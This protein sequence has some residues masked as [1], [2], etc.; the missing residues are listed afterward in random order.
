MLARSDLDCGLVLLDEE[1]LVD[2]GLLGDRLVLVQLR[3][4][5]EV[6]ARLGER[7]AVLGERRLG[8]LLVDLILAWIDLGE[9]LAFLHVLAFVITDSGQ[10]AAQLRQHGDGRDGCHRAEFAQGFRHRAERRGG[11]RHHLRRCAAH[12]LFLAQHVHNHDRNQHQHDDREQDEPA[13]RAL[14]LRGHGFAHIFLRIL[15]LLLM[16]IG[17]VRPNPA[18]PARTTDTAVAARFMCPVR[19]SRP[20]RE[21]GICRN[22]AKCHVYCALSPS[23]RSLTFV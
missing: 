7:G 10:V 14:W 4:A 21:S 17:L 22:C 11:G 13:A 6:G 20:R 15:L 16:I 19:G 8:L 5:G 9:E 3:E 2:E 23:V 18:G 12:G 1:L